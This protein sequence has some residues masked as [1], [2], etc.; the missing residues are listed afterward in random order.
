MAKERNINCTDNQVCTVR[1][2]MSI[3]YLHIHP[4]KSG[5]LCLGNGITNIRNK[6]T[7]N[8]GQS[9]RVAAYF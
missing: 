9:G 3:C 6:K 2:R 5:V 8:R 1:E 4:R 7:E